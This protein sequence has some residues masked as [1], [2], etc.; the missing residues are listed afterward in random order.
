MNIHVAIVMPQGSDRDSLVRHVTDQGCAVT[1]REHPSELLTGAE[2]NWQL[3]FLDFNGDF[4]E[5]REVVRKLKERYPRMQLALWLDR[6]AADLAAEMNE[7]GIRNIY[8]KP[9]RFEP[10]DGLLRAAG[11]SAAQQ[12]RQQRE[13]V[14]VQEEF[15][16]ERIVGESPSIRDA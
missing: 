10:I 8:L 15:R 7:L 5:R 2:E 6:S 11:K 16:F 4:G 1:V 14:K 13:T 12:A 9:V 3:G